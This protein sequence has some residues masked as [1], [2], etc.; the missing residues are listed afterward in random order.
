VAV[1][2]T[3]DIASV[4]MPRRAAD[5]Q[6][7][8]TVIFPSVYDC[9]RWSRDSL[10]A[11]MSSSMLLSRLLARAIPKRT[12]ESWRSV[13]NVQLALALLCSLRLKLVLIVLLLG[14]LHTLNTGA[15]KAPR[16]F[17]RGPVSVRHSPR[18]KASRSAVT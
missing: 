12:A 1:E 5:V 17:A 18:P 13:L 11:L 9:L 4:T 7:L 3:A 10:L 15:P 14:T 6:Q 8:L 2:E 16:A